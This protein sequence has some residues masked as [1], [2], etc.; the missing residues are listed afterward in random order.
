MSY[1]VA[2]PEGRFSHDE[3]HFIYYIN[4]KKE[5]RSLFYH[6]PDVC[7]FIYVHVCIYLFQCFKSAQN[8][9]SPHKPTGSTKDGRE[10]AVIC[11]CSLHPLTNGKCQG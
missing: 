11:D 3:A 10:S 1:L 8:L 9:T 6:I 4:S 2:N 5:L 7:L